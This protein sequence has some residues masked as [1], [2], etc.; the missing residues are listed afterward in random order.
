MNAHRPLFV[1]ARRN[2]MAARFFVMA[3]T[4]AL[5]T[6]CIGDESRRARVDP[7]SP[8]A[9]EVAK[10]T[11][12]N[13]DYPSFSE[14]PA[15]PAD[16]RPVRAFGRAADQV[17]QAGRDLEKATAP[18]TWTL[19]GT[20]SFAATARQAAGPE[21]AQPDPAATTAFARDLKK[22]ATP[23]PPPGDR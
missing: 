18:N 20:D 19:N 13:K 9:A 7:D 2:R 5:L 23:P 15:A 17:A 1:N 22:R 16:V 3:A 4:G 21:L 8:I 12:G 14:I 10:L 6:G 11:H